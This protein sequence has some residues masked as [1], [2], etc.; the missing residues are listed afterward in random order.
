MDKASKFFMDNKPSFILGAMSIN[1]F[2][3]ESG[4]KEFA[5]IGKSNV[6]KSSLIN[7]ITNSQIAKTSKTPGRTREINFFSLN[8]KAV[9]VDM[10]GYGFALAKENEKYTWRELI[11]NYLKSRKSLKRLYLLIDSRR[12]LSINDF[13]FCDMLDE[14]GVAYQIILTKVDTINKQE[15]EKVFNTVVEQSKLH[16]SMVKEVL[17]ASVSKKYGIKEIRNTIYDLTK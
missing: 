6:G 17:F 7:A 14:L 4:L 11:Y 2:P 9:F 1:Q 8:N 16:K 5:F 13:D 3:K 10:P 12:G 15:Y